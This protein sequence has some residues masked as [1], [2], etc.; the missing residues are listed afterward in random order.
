MELRACGWAN[1]GSSAFL[2]VVTFHPWP[3]PSYISPS[4]FS[5]DAGISVT[6]LCT[7]TSISSLRSW[8][9]SFAGRYALDKVCAMK[10]N[11]PGTYRVSQKKSIGV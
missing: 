11:L 8:W 3:F 9:S 10:R 5:S 6:M 4:I 1:L 2:A 7:I